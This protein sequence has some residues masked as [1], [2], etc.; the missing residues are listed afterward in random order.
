MLYQSEL[1]EH[2][3]DL[4]WLFYQKINKKITLPENVTFFKID[5]VTSCQIYSLL[6]YHNSGILSSFSFL[7][8]YI[9]HFNVI[10][11]FSDKVVFYLDVLL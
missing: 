10:L 9:F 11:I 4:N 7:F 1:Q 6:K 2:L 5:D 3:L 8:I